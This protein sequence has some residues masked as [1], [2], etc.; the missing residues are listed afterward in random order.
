MWILHNEHVVFEQLLLGPVD[1]RRPIE[2]VPCKET[3]KRQRKGHMK[4]CIY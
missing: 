3:N 1:L 2:G 4:Y